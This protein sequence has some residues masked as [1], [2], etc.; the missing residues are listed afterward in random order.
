M[1]T[2]TATAQATMRLRTLPTVDQGPDEGSA[3]HLAAVT[4]QG[5]HRECCGYPPAQHRDVV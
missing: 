3:G 1:A 4:G 5:V 2:A